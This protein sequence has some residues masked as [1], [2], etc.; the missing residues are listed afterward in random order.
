M[1]KI[2]DILMLSSIMLIPICRDV[3][4]QGQDRE[5]VEK[6]R[7]AGGFVSVDEKGHPVH[8]WL[9][10]Y[11]PTKLYLLLQIPTI[12]SLGV[13]DC[14]INDERCKVLS[15]LRG[16][17]QLNIDQGT[18]SEF[19][20]RQLCDLPLLQTISFDNCTFAISKKSSETWK[21]PAH[22][23]NCAFRK[24][25]MDEHLVSAIA[26]AETVRSLRIVDCGMTDE[27]VTQL[28]PMTGLKGLIL[29]DQME[30]TDR[31]VDTLVKFSS[32]KALYISGTSITRE[33]EQR[34]QKAHPECLIIRRTKR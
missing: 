23:T 13:V 1:H 19:G 27:R 15:G 17:R 33:G 11:P 24:C 8:A 16:L 30:L 28:A 2:A 4:A 34:I 20:L 32:L 10:S 5:A 9:E 29:S 25:S 31:C 14:G 6:I 18:L 3:C 21:W 26:K 12:K 7:S 22:L